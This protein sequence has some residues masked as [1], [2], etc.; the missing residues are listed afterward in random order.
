MNK[1]TKQKTNKYYA[2]V[3]TQNQEPETMIYNIRFTTSVNMGEI[4]SLI[5]VKFEN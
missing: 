1:S 3:S 2:K 5:A 4:S